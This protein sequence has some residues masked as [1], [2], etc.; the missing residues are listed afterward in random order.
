MYYYI[1]LLNK[2][3]PKNKLTLIN[4]TVKFNSLNT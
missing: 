3:W 4:T 2:E 1:I